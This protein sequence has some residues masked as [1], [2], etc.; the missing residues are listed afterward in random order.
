MEVNIFSKILCFY[1]GF[2][3]RFFCFCCVQVY[4]FGSLCFY[5]E[6]LYFCSYRN[7]ILSKVDQLLIFLFLFWYQ[8]YKFLKAMRTELIT[9]MHPSQDKSSSSVVCIDQNNITNEEDRKYSFLSKILVFVLTAEEKSLIDCCIQYEVPKH[10][11]LST[12]FKVERSF[13]GRQ[14]SCELSLF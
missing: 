14:K 8:V 3:V 12:S 9:R 13:Q 2:I 1:W 4:F 6:M 10:N 7:L 5:S 11:F